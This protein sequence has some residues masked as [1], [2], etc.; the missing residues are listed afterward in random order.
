MW[1]FGSYCVFEWPSPV[2]FLNRAEN[3]IAISASEDYSGRHRSLMGR[4]SGAHDGLSRTLCWRRTSFLP[5]GCIAQYGSLFIWPLPLHVYTTCI[6]MLYIPKAIFMSLYAS[7]SPRSCIS[8]HPIFSAVHVT[9]S[10]RQ[11][12]CLLF[13]FHSLS[14]LSIA[15]F[16]L[17]VSPFYA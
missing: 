1:L 5:I 13:A 6:Y 15:T 7:L 2:V 14:F 16:P 3:A 4:S 17:S 8:W 12:R 9:S 11:K 10:S